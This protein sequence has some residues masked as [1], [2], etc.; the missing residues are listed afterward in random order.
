[1]KSN[2]FMDAAKREAVR[3]KRERL[4]KYSIVDKNQDVGFVKERRE[5]SSNHDNDPIL[6]FEGSKLF[7]RTQEKIDI[8]I[9]EDN[10]RIT[11]IP[12][13]CRWGEEFRHI[14]LDREVLD[15]MPF[16]QEPEK[17]VCEHGHRASFAMNANQANASSQEE[18]KTQEENEEADTTEVEKEDKSAPKWDRKQQI[19]DF[20]QA[21]LALANQDMKAIPKPP[22]PNDSGKAAKKDVET[23]AENNTEND[24]E[25]DM[26]EKN[27]ENDAQDDVVKVEKEPEKVESLDP[28][29]YRPGVEFQKSST[30]PEGEWFREP[31]KV[32][33]IPVLCRQSLDGTDM[34]SFEASSNQLH[35]ETSALAEDTL[36]AKRMTNALRLSLAM[37][38]DAAKKEKKKNPLWKKNISKQILRNDLAKVKAR[39]QG[40]MPSIATGGS[41]TDR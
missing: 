14:Y 37:F 7:W 27:S 30:D 41:Q 33:Q 17:I 24:V 25:N 6:V 10:E 22:P 26:N 2:S 31:P 18:S 11:I 23:K 4:K 12:Y 15:K 16:L 20:V 13:H 36:S 1:M 34:A 21:R 29:D 8:H 5:E 9:F 39:L 28:W 3:A 35:S 32:N 40:G 19:A 38:G